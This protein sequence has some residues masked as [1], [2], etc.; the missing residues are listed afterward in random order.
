[1]DRLA[2]DALAAFNVAV[3]RH[4]GVPIAGWP[5]APPSLSPVEVAWAAQPFAHDVTWQ[6]GQ[7]R[8]SRRNGLRT[9]WT[10][11]DSIRDFVADC[12]AGKYPGLVYEPLF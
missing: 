8:W 4:D 11:P 10:P 2:R 12:D 7:L 9:H 1:M 3:A 5:P 6:F